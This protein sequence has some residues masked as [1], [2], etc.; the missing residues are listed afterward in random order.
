MQSL[1]RSLLLA[2]LVSF[3]VF[4]APLIQTDKKDHP[5]KLARYQAGA[6]L[7]GGTKLHVYIDKQVGGQVTIQ[8]TDLKSKLY[9]DQTLKAVETTARL[10]LDL[11]ALV[12][13]EYRL[14]ISNGLEVF[15]RE[16]SISTPKPMVVPRSI[17]I[18]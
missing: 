17:K 7:A 9:F 5:T 11:T 6:Y 16:V 15:I 12:D 3:N 18:E 2:L 14:K 1:I 13:G 4:S 8:L 10:S